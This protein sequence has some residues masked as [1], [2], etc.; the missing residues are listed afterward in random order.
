MSRKSFFLAFGLLAVICMT[1]TWAQPQPEKLFDDA[2]KDKNGRYTNTVEELKRGSSAVRLSFFLR[3]I[4][5]TFR[6]KK[7][8]PE[9]VVN[10]G[11][12]LRN[13]TDNPTITWVGHATFLVQMEGINFLTDPIWSKTA[14]PVPPLGPR[15]YSKPG[16][17]LDELPTIDFVVIS[18]NHYDHLDVPSLRK[19]AKINPDT[20]FFVPVGN[21]KLLRKYGITQVKE[22]NWGDGATFG[23]LTIYCTPA[24]HWSKRTLT[25]TRKALWSSWAIIGPTKRFYFAGDTGYFGGFR[26]IG[27][28]L[29]PF[30]LA[31]MPIG[32]YEPNVMMR[33]AHMNPEEAVQATLDV[34]AKAAVGMHFGT[35][36]LSDEP[37]A[38]PPQRFRQAASMTTLGAANSW[39]LAFGETR[40]F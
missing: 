38:E 16:L 30:D 14:S 29:G 17:K 27:D 1:A 24:Q 8:K 18:H 31:A 13:N 11:S 15:R 7:D 37:V 10:D 12:L 19:L 32:A 28:K 6:S 26:E 39:V 25:D 9:L 2:P 40:E 5:A 3:R 21:G 35:F 22:M 36:N 4:G 34:R 23:D 33:T 20:L